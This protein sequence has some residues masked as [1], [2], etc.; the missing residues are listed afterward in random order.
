LL[1]GKASLKQG[2]I[3]V[4]YPILEGT[5]IVSG[6]PSPFGTL[7]GTVMFGPNLDFTFYRLFANGDLTKPVYIIGGNATPESKLIGTGDVQ[8]YKLGQ[9]IVQQIEIPFV[10]AATLQN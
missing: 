10:T 6:V 9:D 2:Q 1:A 5:Y 4:P 8:R 3:T 7:T